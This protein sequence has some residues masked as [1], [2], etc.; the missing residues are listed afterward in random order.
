RAPKGGSKIDN[1]PDHGCR[2]QQPIEG[3]AE[4]KGHYSEGENE[5]GRQNNGDG[6]NDEINK[7][8]DDAA[9]QNAFEKLR[10]SGRIIS[11]RFDV[12]RHAGPLKRRWRKN[13]PYARGPLLEPFACL[14]HGALLGPR[15]QSV[16]HYRSRYRS[17]PPRGRWR[18]PAHAHV[19][20]SEAFSTHRG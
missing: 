20:C 7:K 10:L 5:H 6:N 14:R 2:W 18:C 17:R 13:R 1:R 16:E 9:R 19:A 15:R 11:V 3:E 8:G 4:P 12:N